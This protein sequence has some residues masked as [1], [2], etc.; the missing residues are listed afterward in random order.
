MPLQHYNDVAFLYCAYQGAVSPDEL[1]DAA[2]RDILATWL[3]RR[4]WHRQKLCAS[5]AGCCKVWRLRNAACGGGSSKCQGRCR[6]ALPPLQQQFSNALQSRHR[7]MR[8]RSSVAARAVKQN[9]AQAALYGYCCSAAL[10]S[11]GTAGQV[12]PRSSRSSVSCS[13]GILIVELLFIRRARIRAIVCLQRAFRSRH[14]AARTQTSNATFSN[15]KQLSPCRDGK[16]CNEAAIAATSIT[17]RRISRQRQMACSTRLSMGIG[18]HDR[19]KNHIRGM[20]CSHLDC[21]CYIDTM[22]VPE[23]SAG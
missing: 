1:G 22:Q 14:V 21:C 10:R 3:A 2:P 5:L 6:I 13:C 17:P 19:R 7:W 4:R 9:A 11:T 16:F 12:C 20:Y 18:A 23:E 8:E 15:G